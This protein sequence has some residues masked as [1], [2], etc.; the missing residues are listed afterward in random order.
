MKGFGYSRE[1]KLIAKAIETRNRA[2]MAKMIAEIR[3]NL[4]AIKRADL[5]FEVLLTQPAGDRLWVYGSLLPKDRWQDMFPEVLRCLYEFLTERGL[6]PGKDFGKH[7]QSVWVSRA[8]SSAMLPEL[9]DNLREAFEKF[10]E[11]GFVSIQDAPPGEALE[12]QLGVPFM[13]NLVQRMKLRLPTLTDGEAATYLNNIFNG[14]HA[15]TALWIGDFFWQFPEE[16]RLSRIFELVLQE[17]TEPNSDWILDLIY[18]AGGESE[19]QPN[20]EK[21]NDQVIS[22]RGIELLDSVYR[23]GESLS[24]IMERMRVKNPPQQQ[25]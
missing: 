19:I 24:S 25:E 6:Q 11:G 20:P 1:K 23:G 2:E 10:I 16:E 22:E 4:S 8:V 7:L 9:P 3:Q 5:L 14:V 12:K 21:P 15:R 18:A 13:E 17:K